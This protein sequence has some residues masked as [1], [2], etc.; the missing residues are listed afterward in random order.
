M[1]S[2]IPGHVAICVVDGETALQ[3]TDGSIDTVIFFLDVIVLA[4]SV[5]VWLIVGDP[6]EEVPLIVVLVG[7]DV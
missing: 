7:D 1:T 5:L 4:T 6:L 2:F 3:G